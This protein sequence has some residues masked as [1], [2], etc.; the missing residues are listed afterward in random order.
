MRISRHPRLTVEK[1]A[2]DVLD[3]RELRRVGAFK[4]SWVTFPMA[5]FRWPRIE[6][7]ARGEVHDLY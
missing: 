3:V 6:K 4:G 7:N 5:C 1:L 2:A